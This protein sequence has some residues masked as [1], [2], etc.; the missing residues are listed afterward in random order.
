MSQVLEFSLGK[1]ALGS[2]QEEGSVCKC[3]K[4]KF[5]MPEMLIPRG[6]IDQDVVEK[7]GD[8]LA[9]ERAKEFV[10]GCLESRRSV[11]EAERHDAIFVVAGVGTKCN[12]GYVFLGHTDLMESL[13][14]IEFRE[15]RS[16]SELVQELINGRHRKLMLDSDGVKGAIVNAAAPSFVLLFNEENGGRVRAVTKTDE[17]EIK[18]GLDLVFEFGFLTMGVP[19]RFDGTGFG[20][21]E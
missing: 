17:A 7:H 9:E 14:E 18:H 8:E 20:V 13:A 2:T 4:H 11:A 10:H 6:T 5:Q 1:D 3:L 12:L 21:R 16:C 15:A 19:I